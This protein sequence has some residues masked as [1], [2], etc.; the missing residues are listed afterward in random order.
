MRFVYVHMT[1][2]TSAS[3]KIQ[4]IVRAEHRTTMRVGKAA[5]QLIMY[6]R[7]SN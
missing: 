4:I 6:D 3:R 7:S 1:S 2:A 5:S